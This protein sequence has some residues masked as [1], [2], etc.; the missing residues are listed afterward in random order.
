MVA[1]GD[2]RIREALEYPGAGVHDPGDFAVHRPAG[3]HNLGAVRRPDA[4][5]AEA[6]TQDGNGGAEPAHDLG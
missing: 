6:D 4:L 3:A 2:Q 5:M 1:R